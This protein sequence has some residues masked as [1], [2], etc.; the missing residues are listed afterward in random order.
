[1]LSGNR[2][3]SSKES[4]INYI[5]KTSKLNNQDE[6]M[7]QKFILLRDKNGYVTVGL[8]DNRIRFDYFAYS[9]GMLVHTMQITDDD[10]KAGWTLVQIE[11]KFGYDVG[12]LCVITYN[13]PHPA[14]EYIGL[15]NDQGICTIPHTLPLQLQPPKKLNPLI[16]PVSFDNVPLSTVF[17]IRLEQVNNIIHSIYEELVVVYRLNQITSPEIQHLSYYGLPKHEAV[18]MLDFRDCKT[19]T[20]IAYL[21]DN[22]TVFKDDVIRVWDSDNWFII[23]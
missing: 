16:T 23:E 17:P 20:E 1:M 22:Y 21:A 8:Y 13:N 15:L 4:L 5:M 18:T 2:G 11:A 10:M 3:F 6:V 19:E 12:D 9:N 14:L 7:N